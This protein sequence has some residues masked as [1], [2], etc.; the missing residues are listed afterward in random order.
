MLKK[1]KKET[2]INLKNFSSENDEIQLKIFSNCIKNVSRNY[3]PPRAKKI[4]NLLNKIKSDE[5][6]K[7]TLGGCIIRKNN[8]NLVIYKEGIKKSFIN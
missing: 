8:K 7:A 2:I 5:K 4:I 3:Y 6:L 1:K